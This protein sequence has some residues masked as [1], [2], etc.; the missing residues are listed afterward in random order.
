MRASTYWL[1]ILK[2]GLIHRIHGGKVGHIGQEDA[3]P[4]HVLQARSGLFKDGREVLEALSLYIYIV[5]IV[6]P[7]VFESTGYII[8]FPLP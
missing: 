6:R 8:F 4:D 3:N 7:F 2:K 1:G 5:S